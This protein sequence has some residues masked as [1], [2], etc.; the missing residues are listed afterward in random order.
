MRIPMV[1][2]S[3]MITDCDVLRINLATQECE[4]VNVGLLRKYKNEEEM[5]K[6]LNSLSD[7]NFKYV[8]VKRYEITTKK[9]GMTE[10]EFVRLAKEID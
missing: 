1:T 2:R 4:I 9:Y 5:L 8:D 7:G 6:E 10:K 3:V